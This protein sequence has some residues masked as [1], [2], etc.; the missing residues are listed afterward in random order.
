MSR[1][2]LRQASSRSGDFPELG[3]SRRRRE[4]IH[5]LKDAYAEDDLSRE[6]YEHR[7]HAAERARRI[8]ELN[9]LVADFPDDNGD[10][11]LAHVASPG[12]ARR[13]S[14]LHPAVWLVAVALLLLAL[15]PL[16][17]GFYVLLRLVVCG[18]AALLTYDEYRSCGRVS[19]WATVLAGV[20]LLF[21]PL[22]PVHLT[23]QIWAPIDIGTAVLMIV[24]WRRRA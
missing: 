17:Y 18:A 24:H 23:R 4:I 16:P 14:G 6:D 21:N 19:G 8:V 20:A 13:R 7:V 2:R 12:E 15:L 3:L 1:D 10:E 22:I 9:A 11:Y 5:R